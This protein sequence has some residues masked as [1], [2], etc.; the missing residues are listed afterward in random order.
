MSNIVRA[1]TVFDDGGGPSLYAG[2]N[3]T[4]AGGNVSAYFAR[5]SR[6]SEADVAGFADRMTGPV[7][8]S[9]EGCQS[10]DFDADGDVDLHDFQRFLFHF[11]R[12]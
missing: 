3:F 12:E 9:G 10:Y 6:P 8:G 4:T 5:W 7:D 11:E 2:G 1:L